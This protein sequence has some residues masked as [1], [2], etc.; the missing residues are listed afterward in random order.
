MAEKSVEAALLT[1]IENVR[2]ATGFTGSSG[3]VLANASEGVFIT[4]SRYT[5]QAREQVPELEVVIYFSP[6]TMAQAAADAAAKLGV[7]SA[8]FEAEHVSVASFN[9]IAK[10]FGDINLVP[11][12][13]L[14]GPLRMVKTAEEVGKMREACKL[15][16]ACYTHVMRMIQAGVTEFDIALDI[17]FYFRRNKAELAFQPIVVSGE[18]SARPH[19]VPSEK[20]LER[21]DFVTMDFGAKIDGYCSDLTR[22]VVV[23]EASDRHREVYGA[24][25]KAQLAAIDAIR[26][27]MQSKD[28]DAVARNILGEHGLAEYFGHGLGHGLGSVVHDVG[29]MGPTS[30]DAI[31]V[32]QVWTIEP[33]AYIPGFGGVRIE[34]DVLVTKDGCEVLTHSPKELQIV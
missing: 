14:A 15:A 10:E 31:E 21:G 5:E 12:E 20:K 19:G 30:T 29:R 32:G 3:F 34:D 27:G 18:R 17:E 8:A 7:A 6:Q 33:G 11:V 1:N 9:S 24:V 16:D 26:P 23:G 2:W 4:D 28:V 22:T 25:L 13:G